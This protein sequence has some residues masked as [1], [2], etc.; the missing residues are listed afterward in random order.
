MG[1]LALFDSNILIDALN[2]VSQALTEICYYDDTA[3]SAVAWI[4]VM[5][6]PMAATG[7]SKLSPATMQMVHDFLGDFTIM[8]TDD[9]IMA[10]AARIRASSFINPP[11]IR[12]PDA[13]ILATANVTGRLLVTRNR[14]DFRGPNVR[15][16][17][18]LQNAEVVSVAQPPSATN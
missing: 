7:W 13:V 12:L 16:P 5:S 4:E 3:I 6:K 1:R 15:F 2:G 17:Y 11:K 14:K 10:E 9:A 18:E 8:H